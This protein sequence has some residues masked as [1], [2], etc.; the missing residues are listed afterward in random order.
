MARSLYPDVETG[1]AVDLDWRKKDYCMACCDC[2]LV[3]RLRFTVVGNKLRIR[4]WRDN[5]RTSALR[6]YRKIKINNISEREE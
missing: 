3:H 1:Q 2:N 4:G 6:R 5:R